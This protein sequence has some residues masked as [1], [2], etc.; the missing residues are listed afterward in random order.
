M[1]R[2]SMSMSLDHSD[3]EVIHRA[4]GINHGK[5]DPATPHLAPV[6]CELTNFA[7]SGLS[8]TQFYV[9]TASTVLLRNASSSYL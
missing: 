3:S 1:N 4:E 9:L 5:Y 6:H 7:P 8:T 2:P